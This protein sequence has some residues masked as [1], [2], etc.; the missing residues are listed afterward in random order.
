MGLGE[1]PENI[2]VVVGHSQYFK[3]ML[4]LDFKFGN[5]DIWELKFDPLVQLSH[6]TVK[7]DVSLAERTA[8]NRKFTR[9]LVKGKE[10]LEDSLNFVTS[11]LGSS[12][13]KT[14]IKID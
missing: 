10:K 11:A 3:S 6:E 12:F 9:S 14:N 4:G 13:S 2:I 8:K 5:C 1:Q 7:M